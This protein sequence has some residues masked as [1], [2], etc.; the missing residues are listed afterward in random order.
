M[1]YAAVVS[2]MQILENIL[3]EQY[4]QIPWEK[5]Q[6]ESLLESMCCFNHFL[7]RS[8]KRRS[9]AVL[10]LE[11][12]IRDAAHEAEDV[13]ESYISDHFFAEN[14]GGELEE[15]DSRNLEIVAEEIESIRLK[16]TELEDSWA[17][18]KDSPLAQPSILASGGDHVMVGFEDGSLQLK[19]RIL[20]HESKLQI[21]PVVGM[22]GTGKTTLVK[23]AFRDE[24]MP[25]YFDVSAWV[26]VS[27]N[28]R[29]RDML[30][31][32]LESMRRLTTEMHQESDEHLSVCLYKCLK[33]RRYLIVMDDIWHKEAWEEI[34]RLFPDDNMGSRVLLTT[35]LSDVA[36]YANSSCHEHHLMRLLNEKESWDVLSFKIFG[37]EES[38]PTE[39]EE[40][41]KR[42]ARSCKGLPLSIVVVRGVLSKVARTLEEWESIAK[43]L[44]S[45]LLAND[46]QCTELLNFS[47]DHLPHHLKACF[48]YTGVFPLDLEI[49][50]SKLIKLWIAE[51]Y[52]KQSSSKS[53]EEVG[54]EYL[55]DL[56]G[57]NLILVGEKRYDGKLKTCVVHDL[58]R[59]WCLS[60]A[61]DEKF[62]HTLKANMIYNR[63]EVAPVPRWLCISKDPSDEA[64]ADILGTIGTYP[65]A[66]S[67]LS[68]INPHD[69]LRCCKLLRVLD[70]SKVDLED[71]PRVILELVHL[72]YISV[73]CKQEQEIYISEDL[74][75]S[76]RNLQTL[77]IRQRCIN[78]SVHL[79]R[80]IWRMR[81][82]RHLQFGTCHFP[83][84]QECDKNSVLENLQTL[85]YVSGW[86]C[87]KEFIQGIP[88]VKKLGIRFE[89][90][91]KRRVLV[92]SIRH[93]SKLHKLEIL[94]CIVEPGSYH[95]I[96]KDLTLPRNLKKL[97]LHGTRISWKDMSIVGSLSNLE[98][99]KL[100][101]YA[102][103]G[104]EWEPIEGEF[105]RLKFLL[106]EGTNLK[107]WRAE[108]DHL[109]ILERLILWEC[110]ELVAI[111]L[112]FAYLETLESIEL[113]DASPSA[114]TS[115]WRIQEEKQDLGDEV[116]VRIHDIWEYIK[117]KRK[118][119]KERKEKIERL[120]IE[121]EDRRRAEEEEHRWK[122][123]RWEEYKRRRE[124]AREK[125]RQEEDCRMQEFN[126]RWREEEEAYLHNERQ[127][128]KY[129]MVP[130]WYDFANSY[131][132]EQQYPS[133]SIADYQRRRQAHEIWREEAYDKCRNGEDNAD[134]LWKEICWKDYDWIT[135]EALERMKQ[136]ELDR[137]QEFNDSW[138]KEEGDHRQNKYQW[139]TYQ[140]V[141][142]W[143][144]DDGNS[145]ELN[146]RERIDDYESPNTTAGS[147]DH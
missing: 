67:L 82:L 116:K 57:R 38:C 135:R 96:A 130:V 18:A 33:G 4:Y 65:L 56:M 48:L 5:Q 1:A 45:V 100:K 37:D 41:G 142:E 79:P 91:D 46:S 22:G 109:P 102:C 3:G 99:L 70:L 104:S 76:L 71:F 7:A 115:A 26:T 105:C 52:I 10:C 134:Y 107:H 12:E 147:N 40:V 34:K 137:R 14:G 121:T 113:D 114:V 143:Y 8:W 64:L 110:T 78:S 141:P 103:E 11:K 119:E 53:L 87:T 133:E 108:K 98:V 124:E 74:P 101:N 93:L 83:H 145:Y 111:P 95:N 73:C 54:E 129:Q 51:G 29:K 122:Q 13:I 15:I 132:I 138:K 128:L 9:P 16:V 19:D 2:L 89:V 44:N 72:K 85:S 123:S 60:K 58:L 112:D 30:L 35:R 126:H 146:T 43:N 17:D 68:Q 39:L 49:P 77:I 69:K 84:P 6:I 86:S 42:I 144:E 28:Y 131:E 140:I 97:T 136:E 117:Q 31:G 80:G 20:G 50:I 81:H 36:K 92:S 125:M 61:L 59:E 120:R 118:E 75:D 25:R 94:K 27:Q 21:I 127:W 62:I 47:Y 66:R 90:L 63:Q 55:E 106:I 24:S 139:K 88:N 32:L 23:Y